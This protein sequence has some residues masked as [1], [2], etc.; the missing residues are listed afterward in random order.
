VKLE[1]VW[2]VGN[3]KL[4][5]N[6]DKSLDAA[7]VFVKGLE[8][9]QR[10]I[11][12]QINSSPEFSKQLMRFSQDVQ[13]TKS[14]NPSGNI[15][16]LCGHVYK[17]SMWKCLKEIYSC[18][19]VQHFNFDIFLEEKPRVAFFSLK[20]RWSERVWD[21]LSWYFLIQFCC[22]LFYKKELWAECSSLDRKAISD[23]DHHLLYFSSIWIKVHPHV[24]AIF[25]YQFRNLSRLSFLCSCS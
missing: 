19:S 13:L 18:L 25:C 22:S 1:R 11:H 8:W 15:V 17:I 4:F 7:G 3:F 5:S 9:G 6:P 20:R 21:L 23:T 24:Y 12:C 2:L 10:E 14:L 16:R